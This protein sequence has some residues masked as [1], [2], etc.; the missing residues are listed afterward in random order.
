MGWFLPGKCNEVEEARELKGWQ[1]WEGN[2]GPE[3]EMQDP[4]KVA[5]SQDC[6]S[7][8]GGISAFYF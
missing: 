2:N 3:E 8:E 6:Q 1:G 4:D 7:Q 5:G